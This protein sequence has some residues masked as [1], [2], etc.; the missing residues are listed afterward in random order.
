M[1]TADT[2]T[3]DHL[4]DSRSSLGT[5]S[6]GPPSVLRPHDFYRDRRTP[7]IQAQT[8]VSAVMADG[9]LV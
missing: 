7:D 1:N 4:K 6:K 3:Q 2:P 5:G 9:T 8:E